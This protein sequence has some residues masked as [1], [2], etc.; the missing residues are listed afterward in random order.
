MGAGVTAIGG[1]DTNLPQ[2]G[3][4]DDHAINY[5]HLR[6]NSLGDLERDACE[7]GTYLIVLATTEGGA[8]PTGGGALRPQ[9]L[10]VR[11]FVVLYHNFATSLHHHNMSS[12]YRITQDRISGA[13]NA[14]HDG[15]YSNL[16]ATARAFG[17]D[18]KT[19]QRR[20]WGGASK[21]SPLP[22]NRARNF[23]QEQAVRDYIERLNKRNVSAKVSMI[24]AAANYILAKSYSD[25]A[26]VSAKV[27][28]NRFSI[29]THNSTKRNKSHLQWSVRMR[30]I[31]PI[32]K[33]ILRSTRIF[34]LT[35][36]L[37]YGIWMK[38]DFVQAMAGVIIT[39]HY[40]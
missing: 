9:R 10:K 19:V 7:S 31:K 3:K 38:L 4:K 5:W 32:S 36:E 26:K 39:S 20:L 11:F 8:A 37:M 1:Y 17:V 15:D 22:T 33:S 35:K 27:G 2:R 40:S 24:R 6:A 12:T 14:L 21:R 16:T 28:S 34:A 25:P 23:E 13:I 18:P 29:A 30:I